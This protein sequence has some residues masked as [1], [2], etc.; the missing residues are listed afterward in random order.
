MRE[1]ESATGEYV[2]DFGR[3]AVASGDRDTSCKR[4]PHLARVK[5]VLSLACAACAALVL[6]LFVLEPPSPARATGAGETG[7]SAATVVR[8]VRPGDTLWDYAARLTPKGEDV[9]T[10]VDEIMSLNNLSSGDL[11]AGQKI[12]LPVRR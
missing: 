11:Q 1:F 12:S 7:E 8:T 3:D 10:T 5:R 6:V 4:R 9:R 2:I